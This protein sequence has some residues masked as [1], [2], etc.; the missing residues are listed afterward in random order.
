[1]HKGYQLYSALELCQTAEGLRGVI[2]RL[3]GMG[4]DGVEFFDYAGIPAAEMRKILDENGVKGFNSHVSLDRW[5]TNLGAEI[6]YA[7]E[8]GISAL[9]IPW[10]PPEKR[11]IETYSFIV[12]NAPTWVEQCEKNGLRAAYHNHDFEYEKYQ[13]KN[14][15]DV[16]LAAES[17]LL[18]ELDVFWVMYVGADPVAEIEKYKTR[19]RHI[20]VKDYLDMSGDFP[21]F[22]ALGHGKMNLPPIFEK[23]KEIGVEWAVVEQDNSAI[24]VMESARLSFE[25]LKKALI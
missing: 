15:L 7:L 13:G 21:T 14:V 25:T 16:I 4:Y 24:D 9:T 5:R 18:L 12:E 1:M 8:A 6:E 11:N 2:E 20:H 17:R 10:L 3:A 19:L 23:I 22:C